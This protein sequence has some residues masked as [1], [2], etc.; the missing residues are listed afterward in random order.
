MMGILLYVLALVSQRQDNGVFGV[1]GV[2]FNGDLNMNFSVDSGENRHCWFN[3]VDDCRFAW[4]RF[5]EA[6]AD[7]LMTFRNRRTEL[8]DGIYDIVSAPGSMGF[9]LL[10]VSASNSSNSVLSIPLAIGSSC[11]MRVF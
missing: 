11:S 9:S 8:L 6:M 7:Q 1:G 5:Y 10:T 4:T 2:F 3:A